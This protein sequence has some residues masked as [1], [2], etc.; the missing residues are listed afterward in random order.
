MLSLTRVSSRANAS[1][2]AVCLLMSASVSSESLSKIA[3]V[4]AEVD[5]V[6][7]RPLRMTG[8]LPGLAR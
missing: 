2:F 8:K 7:P 1:I 3:G 5:N 6:S 4:V